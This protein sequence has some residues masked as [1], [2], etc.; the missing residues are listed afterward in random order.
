VRGVSS[1]MRSTITMMFPDHLKTRCA[2]AVRSAAS[3]APGRSTLFIVLA[4]TRKILATRN[5]RKP[6]VPTAENIPGMALDGPIP[7]PGEV[8][9]DPSADLWFFVHE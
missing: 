3:Y 6:M 1:T 4:N 9:Y 7:S 5:L 8:W 2:L